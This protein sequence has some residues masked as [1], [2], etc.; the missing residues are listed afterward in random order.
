MVTSGVT[1]TCS[2][3]GTHLGDDPE[4]EGLCPGCLLRLALD[5]P[6][7]FDELQSSSETPTLHYSGTGL[8]EGQTLGNR[9]RVRSLLGRGGMGEVWRAFD[10]KLRVDLALKALRQELLEDKRALEA[11]RQ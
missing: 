2:D 1:H 7:L 8:A 10:L 4:V 6:T 11:L 5:A 3:C 9:Y